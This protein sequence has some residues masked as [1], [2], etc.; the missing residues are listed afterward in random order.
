MSYI[1]RI[2][3]QDFIVL[4]GKIE[5]N[6]VEPSFEY[7]LEYYPGFNFI[8][9]Y[10]QINDKI[11]KTSVGI[12]PDNTVQWNNQIMSVEEFIT[13]ISTN[14]GGILLLEPIDYTDIILKHNHDLHMHAGV[15]FDDI[16]VPIQ[17]VGSTETE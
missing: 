14:H 12:N 10:K 15:G 8:F 1:S 16:L 2:S 9:L 6:A 3:P 4:L 5:G 17:P 11:Y 7:P 13:D